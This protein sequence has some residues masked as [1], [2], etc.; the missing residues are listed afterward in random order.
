MSEDFNLY[1]D[2]LKMH[3]AEHNKKHQQLITAMYGNS[4]LDA[5]ENLLNEIK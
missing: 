5:A 2:E 1:Y 3:I 4:F